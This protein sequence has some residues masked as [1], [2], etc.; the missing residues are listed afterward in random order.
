M[1]SWI[2]IG[3]LLAIM[4]GAAAFYYS[5]TQAKI[6]QLIENTTV[7]EENNKTLLTANQEN[8]NAIDD[9][10]NSY[11]TIQ[12]NYTKLQND[13]QS[14]RIQNKE[15]RDRL[16]KHE[17]DALANAKPGLVERTINN[18]SEEAA[19]CFELLSGSPLTEEE[20]NAKTAK[21][22]NSECPWLYDTLIS[23]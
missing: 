20:Q 6:Q 14:T 16:S 15:L 7:L 10:Q 22:F 9:L 8:L 5:T 12:Q 18:A 17:L 21:Q 11:E 23:R 2:F 3:L 19:R 1:K 4:S 13:F